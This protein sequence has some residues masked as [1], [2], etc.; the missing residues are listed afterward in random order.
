MVIISPRAGTFL[1]SNRLMTL[2]L[3][4]PGRPFLSRDYRIGRH[5]YAIL[6]PMYS[7]GTS[8]IYCPSLQDVLKN[9]LIHVNLGSDE[10]RR[11]RKMPSS[12]PVRLGGFKVN[13]SKSTTSLADQ[14]PP[15]VPPQEANPLSTTSSCLPNYTGMSNV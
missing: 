3:R 6:Q 8:D 5:G 9:P 15:S 7:K 12:L 11:R 13:N 2:T 10:S 14:A 1:R 4:H